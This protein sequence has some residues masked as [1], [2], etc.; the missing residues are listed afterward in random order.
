MAAEHLAIDKVRENGRSEERSA[1]ASVELCVC[2]CSLLRQINC[3]TDSRRR[4]RRQR[5]KG[6][7][8]RESTRENSRIHKEKRNERVSEREREGYDV[9]LSVCVRF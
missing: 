4:W 1:A 6:G 7:G 3:L 9:H 2:V 5:A 8:R